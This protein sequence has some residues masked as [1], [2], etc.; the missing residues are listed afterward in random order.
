MHGVPA[1]PHS[2]VLMS[3]RY[4]YAL[5][6]LAGG[7]MFLDSIFFVQ[8]GVENGALF[9]CIGAALCAISLS[10]LAKITQRCLVMKEGDPP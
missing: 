2:E 9:I 6:F 1:Q 4:D 5:G 8:Y 10:I 3:S 7:L